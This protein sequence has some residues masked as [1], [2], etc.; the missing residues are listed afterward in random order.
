MLIQILFA[1]N[2]T[3]LSCSKSKSQHNTNFCIYSLESCTH[4][5]IVYGLVVEQ[6]YIK[7]IAKYI[8]Y[9]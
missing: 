7:S 9:R 4:N 1:K 6:T 8:I 2:N 3:I 5:R